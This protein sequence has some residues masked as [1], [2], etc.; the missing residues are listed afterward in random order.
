M[1]AN[2]NIVFLGQA[3]CLVHIER[4]GSM[5]AAGHID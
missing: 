4:I 5:E 1:S 3:D 2:G